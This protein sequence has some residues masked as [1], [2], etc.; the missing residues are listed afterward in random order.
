INN[1]KTRMQYSWSRQVVTGLVVNSGINTPKEY[2]RRARAMT[3][4]LCKT[5]GFTLYRLDPSGRWSPQEGRVRALHGML[6]FADSIHMDQ[7]RR[8][9]ASQNSG[10][11]SVSGESTY[12][13]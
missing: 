1:A 9:L 8:R 3:H 12:R 6:G 11:V 7:R 13:R 4:T 5:G 10:P 2:R